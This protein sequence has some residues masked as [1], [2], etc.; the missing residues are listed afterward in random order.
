MQ[1]I[2][3]FQRSLHQLPLNRLW[4]SFMR[5]TLAH[6]GPDNLLSTYVQS[7][8]PFKTLSRK[9]EAEFMRKIKKGDVDAKETFIEMNLR[10]VISIARFYAEKTEGLTFLDLI[11][12]GNLGLM[13]AVD[14]FQ[15]KFGN[16]FSTYA[17]WWIRQSIARAIMNTGRPVRIPVHACDLVRRYVKAEHGSMS[18][19]GSKP[20]FGE[21]TSAMNLTRN[22]IDLLRHALIFQQMFSLDEEAADGDSDDSLL[23]HIADTRPSREE[24]LLEE[25]SAAEIE[26]LLRALTPREQQV[27]ELRIG[28]SGDKTFTLREIGEL[29]NISRERVRQIEKIALGKLLSAMQLEYKS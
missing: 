26:Q 11:Q 20:T 12:E 6:R 9:E 7:I 29:L 10:L 2:D 1:Y 21:I 17:V 19:L 22:Q 18:K 3:E 24:L 23:D 8:R 28:I 14:K 4:R 13:K 27:L 16:K 25:A 15:Y 5:K